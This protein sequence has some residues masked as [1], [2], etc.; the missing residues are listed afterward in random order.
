MAN[1][2]E[3]QKVET[4]DK[5]VEADLMNERTSGTDETGAPA[6]NQ[7]DQVAINE[8]KKADPNLRD[9]RWPAGTPMKVILPEDE[10][11]KQMNQAFEEHK[12]KAA[13]DAADRT[14]KM[15]EATDAQQAKQEEK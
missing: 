5:N 13:A 9:P 1:E 6:P 7:H 8:E 3:N 4:A 10:Q 11:S 2:Q 14:P 15:G 12:A